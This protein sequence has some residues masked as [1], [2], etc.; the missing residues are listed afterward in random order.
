MAALPWGVRLSR[1]QAVDGRDLTWDGLVAAGQLNEAA[2][3]DA[4]WAEGAGLPTVCRE[5]GSFSPHLTLS[6]VG[7]ALSHRA[8]WERAAQTKSEWALCVEDNVDALAPAFAAQ[9]AAV[10][11][12]LPRL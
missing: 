10:L 1:L 9:L 7:C 3:A 12:Q 6:A 4:R 5:T 2:A 8:A 11:R